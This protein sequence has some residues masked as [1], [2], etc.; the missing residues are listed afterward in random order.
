MKEVSVSFIRPIDPKEGYDANH[1]KYLEDTLTS[2]VE[3]A[4]NDSYDFKCNG[5]VSETVGVASITNTIVKKLVQADIVI[6]DIS[7][8]NPNVM[9]EL[10]LRLNLPKPTIIIRSNITELPFDIKDFYVLTYPQNLSAIELDRFKRHFENKFVNTW[11]DFVKNGPKNTFMHSLYN[12]IL[13]NPN[14]KNEELNEAIDKLSG[15]MDLMRHKFIAF[16]PSDRWDDFDFEHD[17]SA[18]IDLQ[19]KK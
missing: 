1:F 16:D 14:I 5:L 2:V 15:M 12:G 18:P 3:S 8:L 6:V 7:G 9:F 11:D 4:S 13:I 10:G 19:H 17:V